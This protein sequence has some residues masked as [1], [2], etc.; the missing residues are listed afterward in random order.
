M[1]GRRGMNH[2]VCCTGISKEKQGW[3][4][5]GEAPAHPLLIPCHSRPWLG[6]GTAAGL[7]LGTGSSCSLLPKALLLPEQPETFLTPHLY[8]IQSRMDSKCSA[9]CKPFHTPL[10]L[11]LQ[12]S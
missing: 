12:G 8:Q 6:A 4:G 1:Q 10:L 3:E 7:A 2:S 9:A 11:A 5:L